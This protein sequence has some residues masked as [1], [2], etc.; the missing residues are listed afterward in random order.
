MK[1]K[2]KFIAFLLAVLF[3]F[4][5]CANDGENSSLPQASDTIQA[6]Y[7]RINF[8]GNA[9]CLWIWNDFAGSE[10]E[11][12]GSWPIGIKFTHSNGAFVCVDLK[13][14]DNPQS[15]GMIPIKGDTG[16]T[17]DIIYNIPAYLP[18]EEELILFNEIV[19]PVYLQIKNI[20]RENN[21]FLDMRHYLFEQIQ[22]NLE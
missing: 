21:I 2:L 18:T 16:L 8:K 17:K 20:K 9:D 12:L 3:T 22:K 19:E 4:F 14:A 6:G 11:K 7:I 13:L 15:L 5:S 10:L 1:K